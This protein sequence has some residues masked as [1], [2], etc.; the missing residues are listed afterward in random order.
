MLVCNWTHRCCGTRDRERALLGCCQYSVAG[1]VGER[2]DRP[3]WVAKKRRVTTATVY[4]G[5]LFKPSPPSNFIACPTTSLHL[6]FT[7]ATRPATI[8]YGLIDR[9]QHQL[10]HLS[11]SRR[12]TYRPSSKQE[13]STTEFSPSGVCVCARARGDLTSLI[14]ANIIKTNSNPFCLQES[15][16]LAHIGMRMEC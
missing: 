11:L 10:S 9:T 4:F 7:W 15:Q 12:S 13:I 3:R 14:F 1:V 6:H 16:L 2:Q 5:C 8:C